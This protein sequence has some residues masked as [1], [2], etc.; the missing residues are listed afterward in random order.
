MIVSEYR[1]EVR[2]TINI[3]ETESVGY[4]WLNANKNYS[5]EEKKEIAKTNGGDFLCSMSTSM[6][7]SECWRTRII[8]EN[9]HES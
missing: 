2:K 8:K 9:N 7:Y 3:L 6:P 1:M 5:E 4:V